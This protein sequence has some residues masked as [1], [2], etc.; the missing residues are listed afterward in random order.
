MGTPYS[1]ILGV[2]GGTGPYTWSWAGAVPDGLSLNPST[3][4]ISGT[5]TYATTYYPVLTV[6]DSLNWS[7][8]R[9]FVVGVLG[10]AQTLPQMWGQTTP[11]DFIVGE[12]RRVMLNGNFAGVT[13]GGIPPYSWAIVPGSG[14]LPAGVT[15]LPADA[16]RR[17][18]EYPDP[19]LTGAA[20]TAGTYPFT[21]RVTD[22]S[23]PPTW[24]DQ[25]YS[26][27][28]SPLAYDAS[29][30]NPTLDQPYSRQL[31]VLGGTP[32]Y[33]N[34]LVKDGRLPAG[35]Q[36]SA[37]GLI[38]GT[39][40]ETGY[41]S[42]RVESH[43]NAGHV[44]S[45]NVEIYVG[46]GTPQTLWLPTNYD[47]AIV[48]PG[49][50]FTIGIS[51]GCCNGTAPY[52]W[53]V[54]SGS[55]P[56]G[57]TLSAAGD[58]ASVTGT[59]TTPGTYTFTLK[60]QD[61]AGNMGA[62]AYTIFV[63]TLQPSYPALP[64][65]HVGTPFNFTLSATG[66]TGTATYSTEFGYGTPPGLSLS[67]SG[68]LTGTPTVAGSFSFMVDV[69]DSSGAT[70][71]VGL[72]LSV[73]PA[74]VDPAPYFGAST[75]LG[76][77]SIGVVQLPLQLGGGTGAYSLNLTLGVLP[78]G[79]ALRTDLGAGPEIAGVATKPGNYSF[80]LSA[81]SGSQTA[82]Q[83][84]TLRITGLTS[85]D[86]ASS[87]PAAFVGSPYSYAL[88][89]LNNAG[90]ATWTPNGTLPPW[91]S[92]SASGVLSGTPS[93]AGFAFMSFHLSDGV[94]T[95]TPQFVALN[96]YA[97]N[98]TTPAVLPNAALG[99]AYSVTL[100][101]A[102]GIGPY[103]Y[104]GWAPSGLTLS[105]TGTI[106]GTATGGQGPELFW[107]QATD[108]ASNSYWKYMSIDVVGATP[109]IPGLRVNGDLIDCSV[110]VYCYFTMIG[111]YGGGTAPFIWTAAGLPP[112]MSIRST[113][114]SGGTLADYGQL[115]GTPTATGNYTVQVTATDANGLAVSQTYPLH[116]SPLA[117]VSNQ[118]FYG[119]N[120][121]SFMY[122]TFFSQQFQLLGGTGPYTAT[123]VYGALPAGL[124]LNASSLLVSGTPLETGSLTTGVRF[125]DAAGNT[126]LLETN[127]NVQT[128]SGNL[129]NNLNISTGGDLG[130]HPGN[131]PY[132]TQ[133]YACCAA[134][135]TWSQAGGTLPA[136]LTLST[137]GSLSGTLP[138]SG[139]YRFLI[140]VTDTSNSA[141]FAVKQFTLT[142]SPL[143]ITTVYLPFS[144]VGSAYS[145]T[146]AASGA[147]GLVA[148]SPAR[149]NYLPPG[150][151][152]SAAGAI[153]GTPT[154]RG[155]YIF[156]VNAVDTA[157]NPASGLFT[158]VVYPAG[159]MPPAS[160]LSIAKAHTGNFTQ[161]QTN[162][163]YTVTVSNNASAGPTNGPVTVAETVPA[164]MTL[165][166][167]QGN[168]W[169]CPSNG[170]TCTRSDMLNAAANYPPI[171]VYVNI[172][173][174]AASPQ[175]NSVSVSG[176]G[177]AAASTTDSTIISVMGA[178]SIDAIVDGLT[179]L[180]TGFSP[181]AV[182]TISGSNLSASYVYCINNNG[183][184]PKICNN[185]SI[186]INGS[187]VPLMD[188]GQSW[189]DFVVP[190]GITGSTA[191]VQASVQGLLTPLATV[192]VAPVT[193]GLYSTFFS[194]SSG[195][196]T[197]ANPAHPGDVI[198]A[199]ANGL[200]TTHPVVA[201][202]TAAPSSPLSSADA[203]VTVTVG[204]LPATVSFA[205]LWPGQVGYYQVTFTV[206]Q[207]L[208]GNP[209]V[210]MTAGGVLS[211]SV[212]LP[213]TGSSG[214]DTNVS[215]PQLRAEGYTEQT[216]DITFVCTGGI[217]VQPGAQIPTVNIS[218]YLNTNVT[219][220]LFPTTAAPTA[221]EALLMIDE[222]GSG[223]SSVVP[224]FGPQA[225]QKLCP[226]P[227]TGCMEFA[228]VVSGLTVATD[229]VGGTTAGANV[230][231]GIVNPDGSHPNMVTFFGVP[232]LPPGST[233][234]SRV[235]RITNIRADATAFGAVSGQPITAQIAVSNPSVLPLTNSIPAVGLIQSG[236][237]ISASGAANLTQCQSAANVPVSTI[238]FG[239]KF[240]TAF[241]TRVTAQ[242]DTPY[243]GQGIPG[244]TAPGNQNIPG[245]INNSESNFVLPINVTQTAG[246][247][248]FGTRLKA[249]FN[250][251]PAGVHL[252]VSAGNV[253]S[254]L[255]P[256]TPPAIPG[257]S[258]GNA[259]EQPYARLVVGETIVDGTATGFPAVAAT[260]FGPNGGTVPTVE[261]PVVNGSATAVW[262]VVNTNPASLDALKFA[263]YATFASNVSQNLPALGAATVNLSFAPA[264]PA[265]TAISGNLA[266]AWIVP[267][268]IADPNAASSLFSITACSSSLVPTLA[269]IVPALAAAGSSAP[270][271]L[272]GANLTGATVNPGA[273]ITA[274]GVVVTATQITATFNILPTAPLGLRNITVT[275]PG[276]GTSN[277][278]TFTVVAKPTATAALVKTDITTQGNW[279]TVYG[280]DGQAIANDVNNYP[281]YAQVAITGQLV[282]T[283][284]TTTTDIRAPQRILATGRIAS[285]WYS[286]SS[287]NID[288]NLTD[289]MAH[290]VALYCLDWD[291]ANTR[292]DKIDVLDAGTGQVL[293]SS[294]VTA[295]SAGQYLVWNLSGHVTMRVTR[296]GALNGLVS[297][298]FFGGAK[299][300]AT[301][302]LVKTDTT[303][304]GN[305][306]TVYGADGQ[307]IA[308]DVTNY[309]PYAQVAITGQL[310]NTWT[311]TTTDVRAPQRIVATGRIA[312]T[313]YSN[314]SFTIDI[315]LT[316]GLPH[317]VALY[318]LD[319]DG[320]NTR[321]DRI[322]VLDAATGLVLASSPVTAFSAG[323]Y[324]VW[325]LSGHV[326]MRVTRT[327]ALNGLVTGLFFGG[328]SA[329]AAA[330]VLASIV[331]ASGVIGIGTPVIITGTNLT[332]ATLN[333]G[334]GITATG[335]VVTSTQITATLVV[336]ATATLGLRSITV[337]TPGGTSN[338]A[339]FTVVSKPSGA[340]ALVKTDTTTQGNWKTVY[341]ADGQAIA[342]DVTN[343]PP[344]AQVAITGQLANT[345]TTT[346]TDVR[347]PQRG[348]ATGRIASTWYSNSSFN[349]DINLTDGLPHQVALYCLDWDGA[350]T[351]ADRIDVLD[352][353]TGQVLATSP[354]AAFS[355]GQYLVWNLSG[356]V[357]MRVT[358]TGALNG[359]VTGLFFGGAKPAGTAALVKIDTTTQGNWKTVY[360]A[361]GQAIANDVT[362]YPAYAHVAI[363]GQLAN[364]WTTTTTDIRAPQ[365]G[366]ATGRIASTWY[367]NS[368][369][370]IDINLTDGLAHQVAL[371]CLDWDG[372]N[373]RA[374][375]IDVLDTST[376]LVLA[377]SPVTAFSAGQYQVWN[378]SGHVTIRVTRTGALN[379]LV[380]GLF[381]N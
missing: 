197:A 234:M 116:V 222:P 154:S 311:T 59:P 4:V 55:L 187:A 200:G 194:T 204:G 253:T 368:S 256:V 117:L 363:T 94:D 134:G 193:P 328:A 170:N 104:S 107:V 376:G 172:A 190:F 224:G 128:S 124:T 370:N 274:T 142:I 13:I 354:V 275:T 101:A 175:V 326:T 46:S 259:T 310:A 39:P 181:G 293:A 179:F 321:A 257:G 332:G 214:C 217:P 48:Y 160:S 366:L 195:Q 215:M 278:V 313:W 185:T 174:N 127:P 377:S 129:N 108:S 24:L 122:N 9:V 69:T 338:A 263:V 83:D 81:T 209:A 316:D 2:A 305:W 109:S 343:Y 226:T 56:P 306:K 276:G 262:E 102:G 360:G 5:P 238:T 173:V 268:F 159:G 183:V 11:E 96:V 246:L 281:A 329:P 335:V 286:N 320:A 36:I 79:L 331:P 114:G 38:S 60:A 245:M 292:A 133:L 308:N 284:T 225:P 346:T 165:G 188:V 334:A 186:L 300:A 105:A 71:R 80:R 21:V 367:S 347:A 239:E 90:T 192:A 232:I 169:T 61:A 288:I 121:G 146:L 285:T 164:G 8:T 75:D 242:S 67:G 267:R 182:M 244:T 27:R 15:L 162:A 1:L 241:K 298:L 304:Q 297:G 323:Q 369:F 92:L 260:G 62:D 265:F 123:I 77:S 135:Y 85:K 250:N 373:S 336:A 33:S 151:S 72:R 136:G 349:I 166:F 266:S 379:G 340:A 86:Q 235:Y 358:R 82:Y 97:V 348:L 34:Y 315:N 283:W 374:D 356:H 148:W 279:K 12:I 26:L 149:F 318:C 236:L 88:T 294:P 40:R 364:T 76:T 220:R 201:D 155:S 202:G 231:Q 84:F 345:W 41:R 14:A 23:S 218:V 230:F 203:A 206:P 350:N 280:A 309:P 289:G 212:T 233:G 43:D 167:M 64:A 29:Y 290:Q 113:D 42:I 10:K 47:V 99:S 362:N 357:T 240:A 132:S 16:P 150:L 57:M 296:T 6:T 221:S 30:L 196:L 287:F 303:T 229:T 163:T 52:S 93:A 125:T 319:W 25:P 216:G 7:A 68:Q 277:A 189:V 37:S 344:Y 254:N 45:R 100:V 28:V 89:A 352:T 32:G 199:Y 140:Q 351:R 219:S 301:A 158:I 119:F 20:E 17:G 130:P 249:T 63:S 291:G 213:M 66:V 380:T 53:S 44:L 339:T 273:G 372:A 264:P 126:L 156:T 324:L 270:V 91:L 295:F 208:S 210:V 143:A 282:N 248:D 361:D 141:N 115:W 138:A 207:G 103:T 3:G 252:F 247:T 378:L 355:A 78:D 111:V 137:G 371:Y 365:K 342:N 314:S 171:T 180:P 307:A 58:S 18:S 178:P 325:N 161:G 153:T 50:P 375:K 228:T 269:T 237:S 51:V 258:A 205:G 317:H 341:G 299:P 49:S 261:I 177:S 191:T 70:S 322:D 74:G 327:G 381:F 359:L 176:G 118:P 73:Y 98:I 145:Q 106:S 95:V 251:V 243:A 152:L 144:S 19:M 35:L 147:V 110:G 272:T 255:I 333:L 65:A 227:A 330:P 22:S 157:G 211:N 337:T 131:S 31:F 302:A 312:S 168:G 271:T 198:Q 120:L 139:V 87:L 353:A 223:A 54:G 184:A 112:G